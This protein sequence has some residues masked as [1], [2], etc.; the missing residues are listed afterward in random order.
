MT[1]TRSLKKSAK[2]ENYRGF[3]II[4]D[5]YLRVLGMN[6][7]KEKSTNYFYEIGKNNEIIASSLY[8]DDKMW[9]ID[10]AIVSA[11][12]DIDQY[13]NNDYKKIGYFR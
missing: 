2:S 3:I 7:N 5:N 11:K 1:V 12:E 8:N 6:Y 9:T 10:S 4:V 13:I